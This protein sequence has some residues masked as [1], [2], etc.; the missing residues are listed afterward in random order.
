MASLDI[1]WGSVISL[2]LIVV[3]IFIVVMIFIT[4]FTYQSQ[5]QLNIPY[6][7]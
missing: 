4:V 2:L 1:K 6:V 7:L 3:S 5:G